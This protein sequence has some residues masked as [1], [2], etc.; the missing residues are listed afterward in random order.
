MSKIYLNLS[1]DLSGHK[2]VLSSVEFPGRICSLNESIVGNSTASCTHPR[3]KNVRFE[4]MTMVSVMMK[5]NG[6]MLGR[7]PVR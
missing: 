3:R 6:E 1:K 4:A 7:I 5:R 2:I